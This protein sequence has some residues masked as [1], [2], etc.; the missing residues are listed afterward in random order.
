MRANTS[1]MRYRPK[2]QE[3]LVTRAGPRLLSPQA[4]TTPQQYGFKVMPLLDA[5]SK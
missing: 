4:A 3:G 5:G 2:V 1:P